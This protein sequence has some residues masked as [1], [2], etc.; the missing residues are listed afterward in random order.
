MPLANCSRPST[1]RVY[2]RFEKTQPK[3][4]VIN[5]LSSGVVTFGNA[6]PPIELYEGPTDRRHVKEQ[7]PPGTVRAVEKPPIGGN[8][9]KRVSR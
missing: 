7:T 5:K 9:T 6:T 4:R 1:R 2:C 3:K 8:P